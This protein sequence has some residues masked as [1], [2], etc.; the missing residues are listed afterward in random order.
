MEKELKDQ[1]E[2]SMEQIMN[3]G[4]AKR[5]H[6]AMLLVSL[7]KCYADSDNHKA[8]ILIDNDD[9]LLTF[10]A[11]ADEMDA[12]EMIARAHEM[13]TAVNMADAPAKEMFN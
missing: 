9:A 11:G 6:F 8:V 13:M 5:K 1:W 3:L 12:A 2:T 10:S 7:A 4:A